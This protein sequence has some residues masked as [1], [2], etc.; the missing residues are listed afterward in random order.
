MN[1]AIPILISLVQLLFGTD[2]ATI[3]FAGDAMQHQGQL[4]AARRSDGTYDYSECFSAV[5]SY[6]STADY[7]VVNLETTLGGS[8]YSGYPC[9]C[10]PDSYVDV[11][12]D[13]GFD[14]MLNANNHT[15]DRR[16]RGLRRTIDVLDRKGIPH[17]GTYI[18]QTARDSVLPMIKDIK[19][20][21][22][23]FLNY[24]YGTNGI[25]VQG[26]AVVDYIDHETIRRDIANTRAAGA[27]IIAVAIHWG[28]EYKLLPNSAQRSLADFLADQGVDLIIGGHPHVIQPMEVRH[29]EKYGKDILVVYSLGNF[30]SN[31]KTRDT[32]GGALVK[33]RLIRGDDGVA[34]FER[35]EYR[36]VFTVPGVKGR[37]N[38]RVI[39]A[40]ACDDNNWHN[41]CESFV[42]SAQTIFDRYN[43]NVPR[44][45][46]PLLNSQPITV[47]QDNCSVH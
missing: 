4:D 21:K 3:I 15:L 47:P 31:M 11:L 30:I 40:E 12:A 10:T 32:R 45:C 1:A 24:T 27:E 36:L 6:I 26:D 44:D 14:M 7:A 25:H 29:S 22:I 42:K 23:G 5:E 33:V 19:S 18:N 41:A 13:A 38:Y 43:I 17:I 35:A 16:D 34:R 8:P 46:S 37:S 9:F 2:E 39:P 20:F 28:D